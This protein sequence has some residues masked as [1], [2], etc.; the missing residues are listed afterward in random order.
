[1]SG[2]VS[3]HRRVMLETFENT[4]V[5]PT[6]NIVALQYGTSDLGTSYTMGQIAS[7]FV[8]MRVMIL[9]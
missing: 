7:L 9:T 5:S 8:T 1:M 4:R 6:Q 2:L 3:S